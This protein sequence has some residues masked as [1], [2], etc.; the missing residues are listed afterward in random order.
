M[1]IHKE[2]QADY[3]GCVSNF[4]ENLRRAFEATGWDVAELVRR[5]GLSRG[6]VSRHLNGKADP[7]YPIKVAY[8][9]VLKTTVDDLMGIPVRGEHGQFIEPVVIGHGMPVSSIVPKPLISFELELRIRRLAQRVGMDPE[10][11]LLSAIRLAEEQMRQP[12]EQGG[13]SDASHGTPKT[14]PGGTPRTPRE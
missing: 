4:S 12:L 8:A 3:S 11:W 2:L 6:A 5:T 10:Q 7:H 9:Q 13:S 1:V 14:K